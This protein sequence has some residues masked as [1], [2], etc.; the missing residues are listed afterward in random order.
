MANESSSTME[1]SKDM[2]ELLKLSVIYLGY[3]SDY[4][5]QRYQPPN[6]HDFQQGE[7]EVLRR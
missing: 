5:V 3:M 2:Y 4:I 1:L 6:L 7:P